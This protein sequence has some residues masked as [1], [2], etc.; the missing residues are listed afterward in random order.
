MNPR[1]R[2]VLITGG[3]QGIGQAMAYRFASDGSNVVIAAKDHPF[4]MQE[5]LD[6]I[7]AAGGRGLACDIDVRNCNELQDL[8]NKTIA[9]FGG[10]D[11]LINNTSAPCFNDSL[12]TTPEQF[13]LIMS[14]SV[15]AAFFLSTLAFPHLQKATN[16]HII[17]IA[18]PLNLEEQWL[19]D[20]LPFSLGK[21]GMSLCTKGLAATCREAKIAVNSLWPRT[22]IATPRLKDHLLPEVYA[23]SRHPL[24]MADAAYALSLRKSMEPSGE[25][26]IDEPLLRSTGVTDFSHYAVDSNHPLVQT[27]FL[28]LEPEMIPISRELFRFK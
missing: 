3:G 27:L 28:P 18:P 5:T 7:F 14:T 13:D 15:R 26:F 25:F 24:I 17:N 1:K 4:Q 6:G 23:G 22:N 20:H 8:V 10:I 11:V 19:K 12:H 16:P 9:H 2:T 21:Y